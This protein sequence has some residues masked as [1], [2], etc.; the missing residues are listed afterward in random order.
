MIHYA[1]RP[2]SGPADE[3]RAAGR[4]AESDDEEGMDVDAARGAAPRG[5]ERAPGR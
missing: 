2:T 3:E 4:R 1:E 5:R